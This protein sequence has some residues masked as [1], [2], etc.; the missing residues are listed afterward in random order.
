MGTDRDDVNDAVYDF[1]VPPPE[2]VETVSTPS[3]Q[4]ADLPPET[5]FYWRIDEIYGRVSPTYPGE[6]YKGYVWSFTT[7]P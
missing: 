1:A 4:C 3:Y 5:Q 6:S 7:I 2:F